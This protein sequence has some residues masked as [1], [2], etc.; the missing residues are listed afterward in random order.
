MLEISV[1][2]TYEVNGNMRSHFLREFAI[3]VYY[4]EIC[5]FLHFLTDFI[6]MLP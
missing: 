2:G 6:Q 1:F 5:V 4:L 3:L